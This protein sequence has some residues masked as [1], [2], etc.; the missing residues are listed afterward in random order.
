MQLKLQQNLRQK[1]TARRRFSIQTG[2]DRTF[3]RSKLLPLIVV[4]SVVCENTFIN[5]PRLYEIVK[6]CPAKNI[7]PECGSAEKINFF[8]LKT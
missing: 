4:V 7:F 5:I 1:H 6:S 8:L 3:H 2:V